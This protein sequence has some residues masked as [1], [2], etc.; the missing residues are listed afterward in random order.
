MRFNEKLTSLR[1]THGY[2]QEKL[3]E[4]LGV[5]RQAVARWEAG[6]TT[7]DIAMLLGICQVFQVS[8]DYMIHDDYESSEDIP[9]VQQKSQE[10]NGIRRKNRRIYL[11]SG[12]CFAIG[13]VCSVVGITLSVHPTQLALAGFCT[14][15]HSICCIFQFYRYFQNR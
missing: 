10:I 2:T 3:A 8:A 9:A 6:E 14:T 15:I 11:F 13:A 7:P 1:K 4:Q 5:S 12:I